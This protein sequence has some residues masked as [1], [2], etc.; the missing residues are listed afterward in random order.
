MVVDKPAGLLSQPGL[1]PAQADS[2]SSRLQVAEPSLQLVHRL[3]RDTSGLLVLARSPEALRRLSA[4]FAQRAVQKLYVADVCGA[5][6]ALSG[7]IDHPLARLERLPPRYG[8]HPGGRPSLTCWRWAAPGDRCSRLWLRPLTGRSHQLRAHLAGFG[9]PILGDPIYGSGAQ[10]SGLAVT[11][12][13]LHALA[14]AF[15]HPFSGRRLR[16]HSPVPFALPVQA[17]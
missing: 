7:R 10:P 6:A 14:L 16:V 4:L 13:H 9:W 5:P 3:D 12:L 17:G 8:N 1:G 2:L 15:R 11:R